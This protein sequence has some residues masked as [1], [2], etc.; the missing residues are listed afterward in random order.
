MSRP[1]LSIALIARDKFSGAARS[2]RSA[3]EDLPPDSEIVVFDSGYPAVLRE[4]L[5]AIAANSGVPVVW[6]GT[7]RFA[8]TNL[9]WNQFVATTTAQH[10][11]CLE[12]DVALLPG[13]SMELLGLVASEFCDVAVPVVHEGEVGVPHFDPVSSEFVDLDGDQVRSDLLRRPKGD[14]VAPGVRRRV[15]HLERHCF[16]MSRSSAE[17]LG[18]LD[19]QMYCRTD[20]DIS[21]SC[22][23]AGLS[24]G[25]TPKAGVVFRR[26]PDL[27]VDRDFFDYRWNLERVA[28]ANSRLIEKWHLVGYKTTINH[29]HRIRALLDAEPAG[30]DRR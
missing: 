3:C 23:Q 4:E 25:V 22:R 30:R 29:A 7:E 5:A 26:A 17:R 1:Y 20:L 11:M 16:L 12:N 27:A 2:L 14:Q 28:F 19:E 8:N 15:S 13:C 10:L 24:V 9:V 6:R 21:L 18:R